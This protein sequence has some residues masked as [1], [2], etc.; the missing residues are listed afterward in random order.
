VKNLKSGFKITVNKRNA[1][2]LINIKEIFAN[3]ILSL[4]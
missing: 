4:F 1:I 3:L 2:E